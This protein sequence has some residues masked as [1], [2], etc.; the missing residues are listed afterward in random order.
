M[1]VTKKMKTK[2]FTGIHALTALLGT[3]PAIGDDA[4]NGADEIRCK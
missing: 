4:A 3:N 2:H 1:H